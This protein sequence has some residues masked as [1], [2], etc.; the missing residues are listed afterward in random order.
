MRPART[1]SSAS[2][3]DRLHHH[4]DARLPQEPEELLAGA[5]RAQVAVRV[6]VH[7]HRVPGRPIELD[8]LQRELRLE[9]ERGDAVKPSE[10]LRGRDEPAVRAVEPR[11]RLVRD[12]PARRDLDDRLVLDAEPAGLEDLEEPVVAGIAFSASG[13]AV[14]RDGVLFAA[15]VGSGPAGAS[16]DIRD[17]SESHCPLIRRE[18]GDCLP[19]SPNAPCR[20]Q[21]PVVRVF[22]G[23]PARPAG[24]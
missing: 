2:R 14:Q 18:V 3:Y 15:H 16:G 21:I 9:E 12:G 20:R 11:E 22:C 13:P 8:P 10:R 17:E 7:E 19:A 4:V 23:S 1:A 24:R 6:E 5:V